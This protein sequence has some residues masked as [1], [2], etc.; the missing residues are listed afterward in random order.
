MF[1]TKE[2][3]KATDAKIRE[4]KG[5]LS[6]S[7]ISQNSKIIQKKE[8]FVAIKGDRFDGHAFLREIYEKGVRG[9]IVQKGKVSLD[10]FPH[11]LLFEVPDT[12]KALG[13]LAHDY[14]KRFSIPLIGI[15]GTNGKTTTKEL[16][17]ALLATRYRTFKTHGNENNLIGLPF[18]L[19]HLTSK[20]KIAVLE[21]GM[22]IPFEI[23]RLS[24]IAKPTWGL[25][26]NV[27]EAHMATM[28]SKEKI[29]RAKTALLRALPKTGIGFINNDDGFLKPY[30]K[31]LK[32]KIRTF[33]FFDTNVDYYGKITDQKGIFGQT[34]MIR[35]KLHDAFVV[36]CPLPGRHNAYNIL[37]ASA[38]ALEMGVTPK[39]I[40][41]VLKRFQ[42]AKGRSQIIPLKRNMTLIYD[43][44]NANPSS[45]REALDL[46]SKSDVSSFERTVKIAVLGDMLELGKKSK[47]YHEDIGVF[48]A[49]QGIDYILTCGQFSQYIFKQAQRKNKEVKVF[50][51]QQQ[52]G[53]SARL[54][55]ILSSQKNA[56]VL[57]K[58]SRGMYMERIVDKIIA[59][60][61]RNN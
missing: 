34:L 26:T 27:G 50:F 45:M 38:V 44:Y 12:L 24:E 32:C 28:G 55:R 7:G 10:A 25:V 9:A 15:T 60:F 41:H 23:E 56:V 17:A 57:V 51:S 20:I 21:M 43:C 18:S 5:N 3:L 52:E 61:G 35:P 46:L 22:S 54:M 33:G 1:T 19:F 13:Q 29:A 30:A 31:K 53:V 37:A 39:K 14:R 42:A 6:F 49:K 58:A 4:K 48:A 11:M 40:T 59:N 47:Q 36:Q 16:T 2:I 8:L